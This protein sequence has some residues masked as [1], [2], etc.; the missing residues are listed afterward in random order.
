MTSLSRDFDEFIEVFSDHSTNKLTE[1]GYIGPAFGSLVAIFPSL[2][3]NP[4][5]TFAGTATTESEQF[6][7]LIGILSSMNAPESRLSELGEIITEN[8]Q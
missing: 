1:S 2:I 7:E 3:T 5:L 8:P 4:R 6:S